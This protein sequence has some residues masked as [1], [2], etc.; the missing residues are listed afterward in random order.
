MVATSWK[1]NLSMSENVHDKKRLAELQALPLER[2]IMITQTRII[3]WYTKWKGEVYVAFSGGKDSTV[4]ADMVA[5]FC[6]QFGY[7]LYLL[8]SNTG[9]EYPE[10]QKFT[11]T[12]AE[13]LRTTY[14]IDV[15]LDIVRPEMRFDEVLRNYGYPVISKEVARAIHEVRAQSRATGNDMRD[16]NMYDWYF[17]PV[18]DHN[19]RYPGYC[20]SKYDPLLDVSFGISHRCCDMMKKSTNKL[21]AKETGR[22]PIIGTMTS[23]S[24]LRRTQWLKH[25]CNAFDKNDPTSQPMSFWTEQDVLHYLKKFNIPYCSVYGDIVEKV[26]GDITDGQMTLFE[27]AGCQNQNNALETTGC[28]RT[29]CI[30][31]AFGAHMPGDDRFLRLKETHPRQ[32]DYCIN[33]GEYAW[34]GYH[35]PKVRWKKIEFV[36]E[37]GIPMTPEEI[38]VFVEQHKDDPKYTFEKVWQPN[39]QGLGMGH[40][41]D[42]IN[43]IYGE[44]FIRYK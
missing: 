21:Y 22:K 2:K 6:A 15:H 14:D 37:D 41:F 34:V 19:S 7:R 40:V 8:F 23:E 1:G 5:R 26:Q 31:C 24:K 36:N 3:E 32:Y 30:F 20:K 42:E 27:C 16:T 10:I 13:W 29:G 28:S 25:G 12:F 11:K 39:K 17:N 44:N 38:E 33:G 35:Q 18:S 4:L 9:L 43:K